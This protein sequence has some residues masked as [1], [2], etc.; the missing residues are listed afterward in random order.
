MGDYKDNQL[1][2]QEAQRS[3]KDVMD[4]LNNLDV[5][6]SGYGRQMKQ[7]MQEIDEAF[8]QIESA[9][10]IASEHQRVQLEGYR[11]ELQDVVSGIEG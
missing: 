2:F 11:S 8:Q 10:A 6:G 9:L 5:H 7:L 3:T 4:V 1:A